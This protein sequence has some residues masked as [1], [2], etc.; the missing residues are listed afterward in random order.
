MV[1]QLQMDHNRQV[2][3][4]PRGQD[5]GDHGQGI[6]AVDGKVNIISRNNPILLPNLI[7]MNLQISRNEQQ[8]QYQQLASGCWYGYQ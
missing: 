4:L 8:Q 6:G 5:G 7:R 3:I 2:H 1:W